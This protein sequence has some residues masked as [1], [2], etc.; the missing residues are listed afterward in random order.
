MPPPGFR[1]MRLLFL[2]LLLLAAPARA[3]DGWKVAVLTYHRFDPGAATAA[4]VV[5]TPLFTRQ[6]EEIAAAK[7]PVITLKAL[8]AGGDLPRRAVVLT[9]DDGYRSV[10]TQM[11]P[12]L[13]R[14]GF[15]A[16]LFVNP[17]TIGGG[18]FLT[19]PQIEEMR[20]SG[21]V[22]VQSHTMTHPDFRTAR[23]RRT[24]EGF[25]A[26]AAQELAGARQALAAHGIESDVLAWPYGIHDPELEEAAARAGYL[27]AF[28]LEGR[29]AVP[30]SPAFAWPRYQVYETDQPAR[31]RLILDGVPRRR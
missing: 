25:A 24:A 15:H 31:F 16:T 14:F 22:D 3:E 13:K 28:A 5:T 20:A 17:P 18:T 6:M 30:G 19:W 23:A 4:T 2:L 9:A 8:L 11:F 29:A 27:A 7:V 1:R 21:L 26:F 12:V 10:Y